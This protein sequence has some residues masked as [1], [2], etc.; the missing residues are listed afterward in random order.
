MVY[1]SAVMGLRRIK[2]RPL[3]LAVAM[4]ILTGGIIY[5]AVEFISDIKI[6]RLRQ[7]GRASCRERV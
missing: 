6:Y 5:F 3:L 7:I 4:V 2:E 1:L